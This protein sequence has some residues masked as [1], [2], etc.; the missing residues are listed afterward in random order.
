MAQ[1][2]NNAPKRKFPVK[3]GFCLLQVSQKTAINLLVRGQH[4]NKCSAEK[5]KMDYHDHNKIITRQ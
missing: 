5:Y 1:G 4:E 2:R 3:E